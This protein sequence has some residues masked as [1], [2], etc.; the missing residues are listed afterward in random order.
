MSTQ[1][2]RLRLSRSTVGIFVYFRHFFRGAHSAVDCV[3]HDV[4]KGKTGEYKCVQ[5]QNGDIIGLACDLDKMQMHVSLNGS[6]AA[7][8]GVSKTNYYYY[9]LLLL[10]FICWFLVIALVQGRNQGH[11]VPECLWP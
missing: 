6:F 10:L 11:N 3:L 5:W 2:R 1:C 8:N 7:P 4:L 9:L